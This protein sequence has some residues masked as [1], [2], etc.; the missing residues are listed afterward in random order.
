MWE[1]RDSLWE[2]GREYRFLEP[3]RSEKPYVV[4]GTLAQPLLFSDGL[5]RPSP[6]Q[7]ARMI[8]R[9]ARANVHVDRNAMAKLPSKRCSADQHIP[10]TRASKRVPDV[11]YFFA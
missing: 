4:V 2:R 9:S 6:A 10:V 1:L 8:D 7:D 5:M 11:A 3:C